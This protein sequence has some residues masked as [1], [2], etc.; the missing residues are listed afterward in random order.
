MLQHRNLQF[1]SYSS[2]VF[3]ERTSFAHRTVVH[4]KQANMALLEKSSRI[5]F[6]TQ[7][8]QFF[9]YAELIKYS[10]LANWDNQVIDRQEKLQRITT[11]GRIWIINLRQCVQATLFILITRREWSWLIQ[12]TRQAQSRSM[13]SAMIQST[14]PNTLNILAPQSRINWHVVV[15]VN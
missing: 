1:F 2:P 11:S 14:S 12:S 4:T 7:I 8:I 6:R 5:R 13:E 3:C 15:T 9:H 10:N